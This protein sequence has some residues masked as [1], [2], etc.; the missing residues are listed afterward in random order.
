MPEK[1]LTQ[2]GFDKFTQELKKHCKK[3]TFIARRIEEAKALG[4]LAENA[5]YI[6][7]R[8]EQA[9]NEGRIKE[10]QNILSNAEIVN[11][12]NHNGIVGMNSMVQV[13]DEKGVISEYK[14]V[15]SGEADPLVGKISYESPLGNQFLKK[16]VDA[17]LE[18][19]TPGG[20]KIYRITR[21]S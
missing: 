11:G 15:G 8:E 13:K 1:Y 20:K 10:I 17:V 21:I 5:D 2:E 16:K 14:I 12:N 9:F 19:K 18:V 3:K 4:D 7:A 6:K